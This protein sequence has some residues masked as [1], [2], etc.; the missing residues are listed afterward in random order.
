MINHG[1]PISH[2]EAALLAELGNYILDA[3]RV[4]KDA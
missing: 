3:E 2:S 4:N 1:E